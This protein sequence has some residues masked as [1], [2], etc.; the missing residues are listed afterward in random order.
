MKSRSAINKGKRFESFIAGEIEAEGLGK[1]RRQIGSGAGLDKG[2]INCSLPFTIEAKNHESISCLKWIDQAKDQAEKA[3]KS[4]EKW[5]MI[6][7]DPRFGEFE[8]VYVTMDFW[9]LLKLLKKDKEPLVKSP[10]KEMSWELKRL[11][12]SAKKVLKSLEV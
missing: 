2:D 12:E 6:F 7:K 3:N 8:K 11:I 10:D 4:P 9:E 1:A 5:L